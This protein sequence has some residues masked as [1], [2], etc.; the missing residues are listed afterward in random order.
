MGKDITLKPERLFVNDEG[1][2]APSEYPGV[3]T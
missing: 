2:I 3:G 1:M